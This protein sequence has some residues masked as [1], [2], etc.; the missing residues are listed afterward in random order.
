MTNISTLL[1][2]CPIKKIIILSILLS[3]ISTMSQEN[4]EDLF[5]S[6][7]TSNNFINRWAFQNACEF[8]FDP[9]K[10]NWPTNKKTGVTF[11]PAAVGAGSIILVRDIHTFLKNLH[12]K[13]RHPYIIVTHGEMLDQIHQPW[14]LDFLKDDKIIAWFGIHPCFTCQHPKFHAIPLGIIQNPEFYNRRDQINKLFKKLRQIPKEKF[15]LYMNF[16]DGN[17]SE[18]PHIRKLF[19][20]KE[21][22]KIGKPAPFEDYLNE[23]AQCKFTLSPRGMGPDCYRT[24]E[25]LLVGSIPIVKKSQLDFLY[26]GLPVLIVN[27]WEDIDEEFLNTKYKQIT[28]KKY[29]ISKLYVEYWLSKITF[30]RDQFLSKLK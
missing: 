28:S 13:I 16:V 20:E 26:E 29:D 30:I 22:C 18:R 10:N 12:P 25:S 19:Q 4:H 17:W 24:W 8:I 7:T 21:F 1:R 2:L 23:M 9:R 27:E 3:A 6:S 11:D 15:L 5:F 14:E